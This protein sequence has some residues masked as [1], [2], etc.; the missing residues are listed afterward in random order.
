M[1]ERPPFPP[2]KTRVYQLLNKACP[3]AQR[4]EWLLR[5]LNV[6][7]EVVEI[8]VRNKP[9]WYSD[10]NPRL[11]VPA[12]EL[13]DGNTLI[14]SQIILWYLIEK[15][16]EES[17][18]VLSEDLIERYHTRLAIALFDEKV[19]PAFYQLRTAFGPN[20]DLS[21]KEFLFQNLQNVLKEYNDTLPG[22]VPL[23]LTILTYPW[24]YRSHI[25]QEIF[26]FT[27][28]RTEEFSKLSD[29]LDSVA[30]D[31]AFLGSAVSRESMVGLYERLG[32]K[33]Q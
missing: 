8:D 30:H 21:K 32:Y 23:F 6:D 10:V 11:K 3:Y 15:Y 33:K 19:A 7:H 28:P 5:V 4:V 27:V 24:F 18:K 20:G 9:S 16:P 31:D 29:W 1:S 22:T 13:H 25:T 12:L 2:A 17:K 14:E 26:Q